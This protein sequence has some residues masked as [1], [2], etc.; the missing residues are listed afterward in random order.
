M[1]G[2]VY[3]FFTTVVVL[4]LAWAIYVLPTPGPIPAL[5]LT[6]GLIPAF[7]IVGSVFLTVMLLWATAYL[8][9]AAWRLLRRRQ[10]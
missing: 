1:G 10:A 6:G 9:R 2:V 5:V 8:M 7:I 3:A 4:V